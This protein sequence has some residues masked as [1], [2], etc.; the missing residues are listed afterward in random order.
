MGT[1]FITHR[2]LSY[3]LVQIVE[4]TKAGR[5]VKRSATT[6]FVNHQR[7]KGAA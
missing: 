1:D 6:T 2:V 3:D 7:M 5:N 4:N